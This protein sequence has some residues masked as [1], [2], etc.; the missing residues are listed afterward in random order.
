MWERER[1]PPRE[2]RRA[3][4]YGR[5]VGHDKN[6]NW[7]ERWSTSF[8]PRQ[9]TIDRSVLPFVS[10]FFHFFVYSR[11]ER[12]AERV[13]ATKHAN[14]DVLFLSLSRTRRI[15]RKAEIAVI[16]NVSPDFIS[17]FYGYLDFVF[18]SCLSRHYLTF[19]HLTRR[20]FGYFFYAIRFSCLSLSLS[21]LIFNFDIFN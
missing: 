6:F 3:V 13:V 14:F 1:D 2:N 16:F 10:F 11:P 18:Y 20:G 12:E 9:L 7:P 5:R 4:T 17:M 15:R 19:H 8:R 21:C